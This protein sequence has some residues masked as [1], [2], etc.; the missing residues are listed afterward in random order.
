MESNN[1]QASQTN[2]L[3]PAYTNCTNYNSCIIIWLRIVF[4]CR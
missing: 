4:F 2:K 1:K 3:Y